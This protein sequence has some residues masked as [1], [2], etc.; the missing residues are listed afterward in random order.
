MPSAKKKVKS[1]SQIG[2]SNKRKGKVFERECSKMIRARDFDC[3][4]GQQFRG[5]KDSPDIV[6]DS[7]NE[8]HF[9]CKFKQNLNLWDALEKCLEEAPGK[10]PTIIWKRDR[11]IPLVIMDFH[12]W[13]DI[14]QYAKG[15]VDTLNKGKV[16]VYDSG[17]GEYRELGKRGSDEEIDAREDESDGRGSRGASDLL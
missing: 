14:V 5:S 11:K 7:L 2:K 1:A 8:F 17:S 3:R 9:E 13:M 12:D 4:R 15:K 6:S 16:R 10:M